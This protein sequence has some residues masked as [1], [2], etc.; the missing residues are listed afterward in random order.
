M[1]TRKVCHVA[2]LLFTITVRMIIIIIAKFII[3]IIA[4][5][6]IITIQFTL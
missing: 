1:M 3:T 2:A 4:I 5:M 6:T